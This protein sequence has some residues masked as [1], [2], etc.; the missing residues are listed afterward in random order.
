M[1][2]AKYTVIYIALFILGLFIT[3]ILLL[4]HPFIAILF[5]VVYLLIVRI[6]LNEKYN[7]EKKSDETSRS[8]YESPK[9]RIERIKREKE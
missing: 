8:P 9:E 6:M 4:I 1:D 5:F 7:E 2:K 3:N